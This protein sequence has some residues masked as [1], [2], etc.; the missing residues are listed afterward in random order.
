MSYD[1]EFDASM[2]DVV[3]WEPCTGMAAGGH[4]G[5]TFGPAVSVQGRVQ[6]KV[7]LVKDPTSGREVTSRIQ[8][9]LKPT[10]VDGA[11]FSPTMADRPTLAARYIAPTNPII[12]V[13]PVND[14]EGLHHYEAFM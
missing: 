10:T 6:F 1:P 2:P 9:F 5:R 7:M 4:G 13:E 3:S 14:E 11:S 12:S 8:L